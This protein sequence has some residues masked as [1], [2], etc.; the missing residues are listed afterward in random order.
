MIE[1]DG[2]EL[3]DSSNEFTVNGLTLNLTSTTYNKTTKEYEEVQLNVTN[4]TDTVYKMVKDF[5]KEYNDI[6]KEFITIYNAASAKDYE[7]LTDDQKEAMSDDEVEKWEN[8]I[9]DSLLRRDNTISSITAGMR[10]AMLTTTKVDR[11]TYSL[12]SNGIKTSSDYT[13]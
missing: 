7:P 12:A 5:V 13:E 6:L 3:T 11:K 2:A 8:K 9:K 10:T 4:D 1:L